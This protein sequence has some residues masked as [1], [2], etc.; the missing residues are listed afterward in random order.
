VPAELIAH[1]GANREAP[2]NTILAFERALELLVDGIE[3]DVQFTR[4]GVA[5]VHHD[6]V[7]VSGSGRRSRISTL[8]VAELRELS[9]VPALEDVLQLIAGRCC[10]YIEVKDSRATTRVVE[11]VEHRSEWTA[12]HSFDHRVVAA[13][14]RL[15]PGLPTGILLASYLI[16]TPGAMRACSARDVWQQADMIDQA[17]VD[18][19]HAAGGRL[20]AWTVNDVARASELLRQGVDGICTDMPRELRAVVPRR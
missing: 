9:Q 10:C 18:V 19:V 2:E 13:V 3:L 11:L 8:T 7:V 16:D 5:V 20:I 12:I 6:P 1:R 17:L 4:D 14:S 15:A